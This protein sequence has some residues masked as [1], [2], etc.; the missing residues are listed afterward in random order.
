MI[1]A[2]TVEGV[3]THTH[4]HTHTGGFREIKKGERTIIN[5]VKKHMTDY[6]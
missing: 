6:K 2:V 4:T 1:K 3:H 5:N